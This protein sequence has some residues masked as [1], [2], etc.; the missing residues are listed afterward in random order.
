ME[1]PKVLVLDIETSFIIAGVWGRFD[2]NVSVDQILQESYIICW[3][4]KWLDKKKVYY[5]TDLKSIRNLMDQADYIIAHNGRKFDIPILNANFIKENIKPPS[6]YRIIDTL[7]LAKRHFKFT[8]NRLDDL[9]K[10]FKVGQKLPTEGFK[11]WR[12]VVIDKDKKALKKMMQYNKQDVLLLERVYH[13][14]KAWDKNGPNMDQGPGCHKCPS[15]AS[16]ELSKNGRYYTP[17]GYRQKY[18]CN[19]CGHSM[20]EGSKK[21]MRSV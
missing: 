12:Q 16:A 17:S 14:L 3:A 18:Q 4:A 5:G 1:K 8:S 2:Q 10:M 20:I 11:L 6:Q 15:C 9:G 21:R 7:N 13:K 19:E